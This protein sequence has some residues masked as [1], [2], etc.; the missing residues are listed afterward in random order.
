MSGPASIRGVTMGRSKSGNGAYEFTRA[1]YDELMDAAHRYQIGVAIALM[2]SES[3]GVWRL[4]VEAV[5]LDRIATAPPI[6]SWEGTWPNSSVQTFEAFLYAALHRLV[7]MV[8]M[9]HQAD[10]EMSQRQAG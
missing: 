5:H 3:K 2:P 4:C 10:A 1:A 7:R 8:E 6:A 9:W